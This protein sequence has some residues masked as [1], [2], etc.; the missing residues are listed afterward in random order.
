MTFLS[1]GLNHKT[2][3]IDIRE[4]FY[5]S[6]TEQ[7]LF[8]SEL[9]QV[10]GVLGAM[11]VSTCNRT[12]AYIHASQEVN[13]RD[14]YHV[15]LSLKDEADTGQ[16][17]SVFYTLRGDSALEHYMKVACG[18]DSL[19]LGEQQVLGQVKE[20]VERSRKRQMM[21]SYLNIISSVAIRCGKLARS[22]TDIGYGGTSVSWAAV[23]LAQNHLGSLSEATVLVLG[24][25]Q[26]G[27][28]AVRHLHNR[29]VKNLLVMNRTRERGVAVAEK[30]GAKAM[31]FLQLQE[32][33][34]QVDVV[35]C[36]VGA[37]H[38]VLDCEIL[39]EVIS[40]RAGRPLL[41]VDISM[42][43]NVDP[44]VA[45]FP[46]VSLFSIDDLDSAVVESMEKRQAALPDVCQLIDRKMTEFYHKLKR[47]KQFVPDN[48]RVGLARNAWLKELFLG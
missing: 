21:T 6:T 29:S 12:E 35:I 39:S 3:S 10:P 16:Y 38:Y 25:G 11:V 17:P 28:V 33:L 19:V 9:R 42:P 46:G 31:S 5:L 43:R 32:A 2:A 22:T 4:R 37:P 47:D 15:L 40:A 14:I 45:S 36:A 34:K 7:D 23:N 8:L 48:D 41:L 24:T 13:V 30:Y 44:E 26:M 18:V 27:E 1:F 20:A